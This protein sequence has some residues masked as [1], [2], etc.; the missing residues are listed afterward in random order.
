VLPRQWV[1]CRSSR[2]R[3]SRLKLALRGRADGRRSPVLGSG[4]ELT[5]EAGGYPAAHLHLDPWRRMHFARAPQP[6]A[7]RQGRVRRLSRARRLGPRLPSP[8]RAHCGHDNVVASASNKEGSAHHA[9]RAGCRK[10]RRIRGRLFAVAPGRLQLKH[11]WGWWSTWRALHPRTQTVAPVKRA[12]GALWRQA[13]VPLTGY[14][15]SWT[16]FNPDSSDAR[17]GRENGAF[18]MSTTC[19]LP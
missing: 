16:N 13:L 18:E 10:P 9:E 8:R 5:L 11:E 1:G 3:S 19:T 6:A 12:P 15:F 4:H 17:S 2:S 14:C 7:I